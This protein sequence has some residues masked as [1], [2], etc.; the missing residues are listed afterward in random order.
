MWPRSTSPEALYAR[1]QRLVAKGKLDKAEKMFLK[2]REMAPDH[3][4]VVISLAVVYSNRGEYER[5]LSA[6]RSVPDHSRWEAL[7]MR[8]QILRETHRVHEAAEA[9]R[10][11]L[12]LVPGHS[13]ALEALR[14]MGFRASHHPVGQADVLTGTGAPPYHST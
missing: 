13:G 10:E 9:F 5:A 4:R 12:K 1:G 3:Y 7:L 6:L 8:G 14:A 11:A 2:L